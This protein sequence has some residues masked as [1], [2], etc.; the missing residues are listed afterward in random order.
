MTPKKDEYMRGYSDGFKDGTITVGWQTID[1]A[2]KNRG[3]LIDIWLESGTRWCDCYYDQICDEWRTSRPSGHL[4]SIKAKHVTHWREVTAGPTGAACLSAS[5]EAPSVMALIR[6][7]HD[8]LHEISPDNYD[9]DEVCKLNDASVEVILGLAHYLGEK[10]GKTDEWWQEYRAKHP[11]LATMKGEA[12]AWQLPA[13]EIAL[14]KQECLK[15]EDIDGDDKTQINRVHELLH[16]FSRLARKNAN[17]KWAVSHAFE[18][19]FYIATKDQRHA[20]DVWAIEKAAWLRGLAAPAEEREMAVR[21]GWIEDPLARS[22]LAKRYC[23]CNSLTNPCIVCGLPKFIDP[24]SLKRKI[25][26]DGDEGEIGA[27]FE[28][29][30]LPDAHPA[31]ADKGA[32]V[33]ED[34]ALRAAYEMGRKQWCPAGILADKE[35]T[36]RDWR[37]AKAALVQVPR[38]PTPGMLEAWYRYKSGHHWPDEEPPADTSDVGA[39]KAMLAACP[40]EHVFLSQPPAGETIRSTQGNAMEAAPVTGQS[41]VGAVS[42]CGIAS[43]SYHEC[44]NMKEVGGGMEGERYWCAICSKGYY[45]DYEDMK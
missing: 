27:G 29:F 9:H 3:R 23:Q 24:E 2:P 17:P 36:E 10:H 42:P 18:L 28:L 13:D 15:P 14:L 6:W 40:T 8:T 26:Q 45:L 25:E 1:S 20:V 22:A 30:P 34:G 11:H 38:E 43:P 12:V 32:A 31:P 44:P 35:R 4:I 21:H 5:S 37:E 39:Y 41:P 16:W 7:A 33:S 19:A